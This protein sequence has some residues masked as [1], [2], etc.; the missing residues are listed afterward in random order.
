[1]KP[2][3]E[4]FSISCQ[5]GMIVRAPATRIRGD[6]FRRVVICVNPAALADG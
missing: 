2:Y 4:Y 5:S 1:M 3:N 6:R